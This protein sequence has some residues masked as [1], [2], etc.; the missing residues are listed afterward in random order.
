[1]KRVVLLLNNLNGIKKHVEVIS[2]DAVSGCKFCSVA[3]IYGANFN[4]N[5]YI[6][7]TT[8]SSPYHQISTGIFN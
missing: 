8:L 7:L 6:I 5:N 3:V 1:M 4:I 2:V